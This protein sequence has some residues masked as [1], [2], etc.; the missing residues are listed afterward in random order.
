MLGANAH[1]EPLPKGTATMMIVNIVNLDVVNL[2]LGIL[3]LVF[4]DDLEV[5]DYFQG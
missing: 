1:R 4:S 2:V 5:Q 3:I